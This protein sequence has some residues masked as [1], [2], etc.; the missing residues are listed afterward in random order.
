MSLAANSVRGPTKPPAKGS[1]P[2][3]RDHRCSTEQHRYLRCL[4]QQQQQQ[5]QQFEAYDHLPC[6]E[7]A[8]AFLK[9]RMDTNLMQQEDFEQLGFAASP[10]AAAAAGAAAAGAAGAAA[11]GAAAAGRAGAA[12]VDSLAETAASPEHGAPPTAPAA[13]AA[14]PAAPAPAAAAAAKS[15]EETGYLAGISALQPYSNRGFFGRVVARFSW[16][17]QFLQPFFSR[18]SSSSSSSSGS[19][20]SSRKGMQL[21]PSEP[22][23]MDSSSSSNSSSSSGRTSVGF[24]RLDHYPDSSSN[25]SS[26]SRSSSDSAAAV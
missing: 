11:A 18:S 20:S 14:A 19:S 22:S 15:K 3:D 16:P 10:Q 1:F 7:L 17:K 2:L 24:D 9:C 13:A 23:D 8:K 21:L 4:T 26:N 12:A 5:Q 6:R 25:S